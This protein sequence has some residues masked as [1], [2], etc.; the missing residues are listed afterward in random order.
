MK[1]TAYAITSRPCTIRPANPKRPWMDVAMNKAP[2]RCLPL[3]M[4]NGWGWEILSNAKF[5]AEWNGGQK[6][7]DVKVTTL[8]GYGAPDGYF[9]EGTLTWHSGYMFRTPYP[10]GIYVTGVPNNPKPNAIPL[11]G[12]V[13]TNWLPFSFTMNWRFTQPGEFTMEI[14][15]PFCQIFPID[16]T[17]FDN[18][19][20]EIRSLHEPEAK[21]LSDLYWDWTYSRQ[22]Y[23]A[24]QRAGKLAANIWQKN[25]M[26]GTYPAGVVNE[27]PAECPFHINESGE[28][29]SHHRTKSNAPEF[30]DNRIGPFVEP[31]EHTTRITEMLQREQKQKT[32]NRPST[33]MKTREER[34]ADI[35]DRLTKLKSKM[36]VSTFAEIKIVRDEPV[37]Q[38]AQPTE[39]PTESREDKL[40]RIQAELMSKQRK[41]A[42]PAVTESRE[43]KLKRIQS[44]LLSKQKPNLKLI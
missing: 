44:E 7:S 2:Y 37:Q 4:A 28:K 24:Q 15:E 19:E 25:Y 38:P 35:Q 13:E 20:P 39:V 41:S 40:K 12:I 21:E 1:L 42:E 16:M 17:T 14:G 29:E 22:E 3:S 6:P 8:D 30:T 11:S 23:S 33:T 43:D 26:R 32:E 31:K 10:Y 18:I 36:N 9:G 27:K 5:V 34:L